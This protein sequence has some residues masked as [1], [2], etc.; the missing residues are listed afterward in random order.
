MCTDHVERIAVRGSA[1]GARGW[2][3]IDEARVSFDHPFHAAVE[4]AVLIDLVQGSITSERVAIEL[5]A[6]S[7]RDL[8]RAI[9]HVLEVGGSAR[10]DITKA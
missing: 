6:P 7:A 3:T 5:S 9:E 1:K 2:V 4:S 8:I 10:L